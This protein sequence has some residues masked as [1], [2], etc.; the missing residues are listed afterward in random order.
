MTRVLSGIRV[1]GFNSLAGFDKEE[2]SCYKD[3]RSYERSYERSR[4]SPLNFLLLAT[5][6]KST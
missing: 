5:L 4:E 3:E 1:K 6:F 2:K